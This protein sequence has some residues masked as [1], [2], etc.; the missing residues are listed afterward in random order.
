MEVKQKDKE[1]KETYERGFLC[2]RRRNVVFGVIHQ[3]MFFVLL[4][5]HSRG[6]QI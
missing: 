2:D 6:G 4:E 3:Q 1:K 5:L